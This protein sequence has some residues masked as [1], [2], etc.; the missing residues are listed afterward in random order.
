MKI[1]R[2][3]AENLARGVI[4]KRTL[5]S[6]VG[7][8]KIYVSPD[9]QLKYLKLNLGAA[10]RCLLDQARLLVGRSTNVSGQSGETFML[11]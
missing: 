5:P 8:A 1:L 4:I 11:R 6:N 7:G 3:L 9:A 10:E 2:G